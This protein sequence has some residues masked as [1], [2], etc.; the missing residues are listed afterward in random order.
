MAYGEADVLLKDYEDERSLNAMEWN[1][2]QLVNSSASDTVRFLTD[3]VLE[4]K[5]Q[6]LCSASAHTLNLAR[7]DPYLAT[8]LR[9]MDGLLPDG[10]GAAAAAQLTGRK[11]FVN[12]NPRDLVPALL[13]ALPTYT[14]FFIL[15]ARRAI[16][17]HVAMNLT[18]TWPHLQLV[19]CQDSSFEAW[20]SASVAEKINKSG[21]EVVFTGMDAPR[22]ELW[23]DR[24]AD[25]LDTTLVLGVSGFFEFVASHAFER[26]IGPNGLRTKGDWRP[27][28]S[29]P[30]VG[31]A[32]GL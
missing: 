25:R 22:Q 3:C 15:G 6:R 4:G 26:P 12:L 23:M 27:Q 20:E 31:R 19:G 29:G 10:S 21:A 17:P 13:L 32:A 11:L 7:H 18:E 2:C 28:V 8:A 16:T 9:R 14:R 1:G 5:R 30:L 24:Y